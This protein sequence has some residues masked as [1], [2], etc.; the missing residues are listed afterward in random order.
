[1]NDTLIHPMPVLVL[2]T[3]FLTLVWIQNLVE[4][5]TQNKNDIK[6]KYGISL[7][8]ENFAIAIAISLLSAVIT[9][10]INN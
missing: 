4:M 2:V 5:H 8:T 1:M 6:P 7:S 9:Y 10:S 3:V